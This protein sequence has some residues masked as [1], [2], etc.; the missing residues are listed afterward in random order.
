MQKQ[1][2]VTGFDRIHTPDHVFFGQ[3]TGIRDI[4]TAYRTEFR[5][6]DIVFTVA[7]VQVITR[8][9]GGFVQTTLRQLVSKDLFACTCLQ[10]VNTSIAVTADQQT[11][12]VDDRDKGIRVIGIFGCSTW[13]GNPQQFAVLLV[14]AIVGVLGAGAFGITPVGVKKADDD[15]ILVDDRCLR[16]S[17]ITRDL[18]VFF[19]QRVF[20]NDFAVAGVAAED[21]TD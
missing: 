19:R 21:S 20:P 4:D 9:D 1:S 11:L 2:R 7:Y 14:K 8:D 16:S 13:L 12:A 18:S 10:T 3:I 17:A 6:V 15:S 5:I